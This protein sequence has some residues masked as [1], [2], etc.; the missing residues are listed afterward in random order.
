M[1]IR[2]REKGDRLQLSLIETR[3]ISGKVQHEHIASLGAVPTPPSVADRIAFWQ[4]LHE[5]LAKLTSRVDPATQAKLLGAIHERVPM[6]TADEQ[7]ATQ[8]ANAEADARFWDSIAR[9][10]ADTGEDHKALIATAERTA[11]RN[12]AKRANAA[13]HAAKAR[14]RIARIERGE[15]VEGG[16][17]KPMT[18]EDWVRILRAAGM[19][20]S[21]ITPELAKLVPGNLER[22][23][24]R[25]G[26]ERTDWGEHYG[27]PKAVR[28]VLIDAESTA[29]EI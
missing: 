5:R 6:V 22:G 17:G 23:S 8:R 2:F 16:L 28:T 4:H 12:E 1:F 24:H 29:G 21:D 19:T 15:N 3:R 26:M 18:P 11:A 20:A 13:E 7:T 14:E 25:L 27:K 10:N 9:M